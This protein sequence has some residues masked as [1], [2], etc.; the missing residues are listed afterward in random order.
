MNFPDLARLLAGCLLALQGATVSASFTDSEDPFF[1]PLPV[2]LTVSRLPQPMQ[3]TPGAVSVIDSDLIKASG[4]RD[5]ARLLRLIPGIQVAQER[6]NE[7][8]VSYHGLGADY[9]N[10]MQ[11]L[12]DGR[13]VYSPNFFGGADWSALG[14]NIEDID[15]IEVVRG[16]DSA[17]YGSNAFLG[18]VNIITRHTAAETDSLT[19][20]SLGNQGIADISVR[21][22]INKDSIGL[23]ISA[24]HIQDDGSD[25]LKDG[26]RIDTLNLRSDIRMGNTD[27]LSVIGGASAGSRGAGYEGV[28][29]DGS[30]PRTAYYQNSHLQ[31]RWLHSPSPDEEMSLSWYHN[32]ERARE[33]WVVDSRKNLEGTLGASPAVIAALRGDPP[34]FIPHLVISDGINQNRDSSRD[35]I[36]F[37]HRYR[38]SSQLQLLWGMEWRHDTLSAA[39]LFNDD[40]THS[41]YEWRLFGNA[42]WRFN[43]QWLLNLGSM[44]EQIDGDDPQLAPRVFLNWQPD[45]LTTLRTGISRAWRQ[46]TLFER[47]ADTRVADPV[48]GIIQR[49]QLGNPD[50]KPQRIDALEVGLLRQLPQV[51][52]NLDVRLFHERI[53]DYI[54]RQSLPPMLTAADNSLPDPNLFQRILGG[55]RWE[56]SDG[57][58]RLTGIEYQLRLKPWRDGQLIVNHTLIRADAERP[59]VEGTVAP[60]NA[61]LS[62]LQRFGPWQSMLTLLRTGPAE[63]GT[64]YAGNKRFKADAYNSVDISIARALQISGHLVE[65][66]LSGI[67]L[68]GKHQEMVHRPVELLTEYAGNKA[69]NPIEPQIYLSMSSRF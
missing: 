53:R 10:Q 15:R 59:E 54:V 45:G 41:Q 62:W 2:V 69:A 23:R 28:L 9:P 57:L 11:V 33:E 13:S 14:I 43:P 66:R 55:T 52:G 44:L 27:E 61:S 25:R 56:N 38:A 67:N 17:A 64:G 19:S 18:V 8:W 7:Q 47:E 1:E 37:Q 50:L 29:F 32:R 39:T 4:Y 51:S 30:A 60:Y 40:R 3:D 12:I 35:N 65:F 22:T 49:R 68:L 21:K 34:Y 63:I 42:E 48:Y 16:S 24:S 58:V 31:L 36:E 5:I 26:R 46:P 20:I 6:S